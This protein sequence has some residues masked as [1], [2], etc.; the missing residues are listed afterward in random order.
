MSLNDL[1]T[2]AK[3]GNSFRIIAETHQLSVGVR[4]WISESQMGDDEATYLGF[5]VRI[6]M[7][8]GYPIP[9]SFSHVLAVQFPDM[10]FTKITASYASWSGGWM[11]AYPISEMKRIRKSIKNNHLGETMY[12]LWVTN[13]GADMI[14]M[15]KQEFLGI[16]ESELED[17]FAEVI[18]QQD[19]PLG[20]L[21]QFIP[22]TQ[23]S[24]AQSL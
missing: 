5:R 21:I 22:Q 23:D 2:N 3:T 9:L 8:E 4:F 20:Q 14:W 18:P 17:Y 19:G 7:R 12:D 1:M 10:E 24:E 6:E 16:F 13:L 15:P 11:L